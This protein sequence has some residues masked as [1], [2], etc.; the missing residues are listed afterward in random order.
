MNILVRPSQTP[1][2]QCWQV[3]LAQQAVNFRSE[4]EAR[5]FVGRLEARLR[6]PHVLPELKQRTA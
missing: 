3:C 6:A 1:K 2:G 4:S 5:R